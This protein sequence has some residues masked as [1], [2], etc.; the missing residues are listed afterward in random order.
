MHS[1]AQGHWKLIRHHD[2]AITAPNENGF[3]HLSKGKIGLAWQIAAVKAV[4]VAHAVNETAHRHF[5]AGVLATDASH[6]L[7][8]PLRRQAIGQGANGDQGEL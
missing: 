3:S 2:R 4:T 7:A 1:S 5:R 8:A 6:A